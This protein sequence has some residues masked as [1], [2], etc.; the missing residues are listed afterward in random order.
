MSR[1]NR[2]GIIFLQ[3][4]NHDGEH[5]G[6]GKAAIGVVMADKVSAVP[7]QKSIAAENGEV[8]GSQSDALCEASPVADPLSHLQSRGVGLENP[9][10][11]HEG[12]HCPNLSQCLEPI[13]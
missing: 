9:R 13:K 5:G 2:V 6:D 4:S 8:G 10:L 1:V 3:S 11:A 7:Q 12:L